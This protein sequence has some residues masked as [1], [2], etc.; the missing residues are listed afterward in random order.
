MDHHCPWINGC[1][2]HFNHRYFFLYMT[3]TVLG[4]LFIMVSMFNNFSSQK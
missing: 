4:C 1:I 3:Y 2:G